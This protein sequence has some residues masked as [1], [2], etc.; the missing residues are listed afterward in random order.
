MY[1]RDINILFFVSIMQK[2]YSIQNEE[3]VRFFA[4]SLAEVCRRWSDKRGVLMPHIPNTV[5]L[6]KNT[7]KKIIAT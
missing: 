6:P 4:V 3:R 7:G 5:N 2:C 1:A